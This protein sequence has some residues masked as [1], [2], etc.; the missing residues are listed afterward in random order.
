MEIIEKLNS[1]LNDLNG[2]VVDVPTI[3]KLV[4]SS[5]KSFRSKSPNDVDRLTFLSALI[6]IMDEQEIAEQLLDFLDKNTGEFIDGRLDLAVSLSMSRLLW[7][8]FLKARGE[9]ELSRELLD[10]PDI[11]ASF[12]LRNLDPANLDILVE[13]SP[14][15]AKAR[16]VYGKSVIQNFLLDIDFRVIAEESDEGSRVSDKLRICYESFLELIVVRERSDEIANVFVEKDLELLDE[17]ILYYKEKVFEY[18]NV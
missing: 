15:Y 12:E 18:L 8:H 2:P 1:I 4:K 9:N 5:R 6:Y 7:R 17:E 13:R 14:D 16:F 3:S 11:E 10:R